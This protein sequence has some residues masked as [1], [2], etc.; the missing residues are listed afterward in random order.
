MTDWQRLDPRMLLVHP[1][2]ELIRL[3]PVLLAL[4]FLNRGD[5][6]GIAWGLMGA[7]AALAGP[8][9]ALD[10]ART[11][12]AWASGFQ[13]MELSGAFQ[14][15]GSVSDAFEFGLQALVTGL[16]GHPASE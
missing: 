12:T 8:E 6:S 3:A 1:V 4:V 7:A 16:G 15:G 10:A 9:H 2:H 11:V 14:L 5:R 13:R